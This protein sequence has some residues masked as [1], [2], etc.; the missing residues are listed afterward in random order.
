MKI[1]DYNKKEFIITRQILLSLKNALLSS[2]S[3]SY[4][5]EIIASLV[6]GI[7]S[8]NYLNENIGYNLTQLIP[9][10]INEVDLNLVKISPKENARTKKII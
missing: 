1:T 8:G 6:H 4:V 3:L 9:N 7:L 5:S 2:N 10:L